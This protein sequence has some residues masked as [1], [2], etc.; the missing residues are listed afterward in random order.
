MQN[1]QDTEKK[2]RKRF[3]LAVRDLQPSKDV[4]GGLIGILAQR[5]E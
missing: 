1:K 4:K 2:G 3:K 5:K